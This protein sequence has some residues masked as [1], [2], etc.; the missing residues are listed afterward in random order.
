MKIFV[1]D[2]FNP[3]AFGGWFLTPLYVPVCV[4]FL[5]G[6]TDNLFIAFILPILALSLTTVFIASCIGKSYIAFLVIT[7]PLL[8]VFSFLAIIT[9]RNMYLTEMIIVLFSA[10]IAIVLPCTGISYYKRALNFFN[11]KYFWTSAEKMSGKTTILRAILWPFFVIF[12]FGLPIFL[13]FYTGNG[14]VNSLYSS[15]DSEF[16]FFLSVIL[17]SGLVFLFGTFIVGYWRIQSLILIM[18]ISLIFLQGFAL[19]LLPMAALVEWVVTGYYGNDNKI[20]FVQVMK[21]IFKTG[22]VYNI[23]KLKR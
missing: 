9:V 2:K 16:Y 21:Y 10:I 1:E 11:R 3:R 5:G 23:A 8:T 14:I 15:S 7:M 4:A 19:L 6:N 12:G 22:R 20:S 17:V 13:I 18:L